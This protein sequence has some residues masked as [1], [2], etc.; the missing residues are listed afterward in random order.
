MTT[1]RN[2]R[3][4]D[5]GT[6]S[7]LY[8]HSG[9]PC[10]AEKE[11]HSH[12]TCLK[13]VN[14]MWEPA[15]KFSLDGWA[16]FTCAA[17]QCPILPER[18]YANMERWE[19]K[20]VTQNYVKFRKIYIFGL[21]SEWPQ[22]I[23]ESYGKSLCVIRLSPPL[24]G[25]VWKSNRKLYKNHHQ[26]HQYCRYT[27]CHVTCVSFTYS[28]LILFAGTVSARSIGSTKSVLSTTSV[29]NASSVVNYELNKFSEPDVGCERNVCSFIT[30]STFYLVS[31]IEN[32]YYY[33]KY[34]SLCTRKISLF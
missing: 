4:I 23:L 29:A 16:N 27:A 13:T 33:R 30:Q 19:W 15:I 18:S 5:R 17:C 7:R 6:N 28:I 2:F 32:Q 21:V 14:G 8:W 31:C 25:L 3:R 22:E 20:A 9:R 26:N 24:A 1:K 34:F 11:C 10:R 12:Y